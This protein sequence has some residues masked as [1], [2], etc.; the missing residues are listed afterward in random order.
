MAVMVDMCA[1]KRVAGLTLCAAALA[2]GPLRAADELPAGAEAQSPVQR[3]V[4]GSGRVSA[5]NVPTSWSEAGG[6]NLLWKAPIDL[7]AW[8]SPIVWK[9]RVIALGADAG[10]RVAVCLNAADGRRLWTT[11]IAPCEG[12]VGSYK[13]Y[14]SDPD[15]RWDRLLHAGATPATNGRQV[16]ALFSN[17][18]L[19]ALDL[20]DGKLL[21][22]VAAGSPAGNTYGQCSSLLVFRNTVIAV[23]QGA[24]SSIAAY[25]AATGKAVW[26]T[27]RKAASWASPI[28]IT[29]PAGKWQVV[30]PASPSV[31]AW[32]AETGR[33]AW[34]L[35]LLT[36]RAEYCVGPSP[37]YA[38]GLVFICAK[39]SGIFAVDP[40]KGAKVWGVETL[41]EDAPVAEFISMVSDGKH[42]FHYSDYVLTCLDAKTGKVVRQKE[43]DDLA[44]IANPVMAGGRLYLST[45]DGILAV[46]A[47]PSGAFGD[48]VG[49][50]VIKDKCDSTAAI[51]DGRVFLRTDTA[52]YAL[53]AK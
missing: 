9:D 8:A 7:P 35:D 6:T 28:L 53:G 1:V 34:S 2:A 22:S 19:A 10:K 27:P 51:V 39:G 21:W 30:L 42:V 3:G 11:E 15:L 48:V 29:T 41:P 20:A 37:V 26:K 49:K 17:G 13:I 50:G 18:Q 47:D 45:S 43:F 38:D 40:D 36:G 33:E 24:D 25:D 23:V 16:F 52:V 14:T 31:T 5:T 12:L 46:Q 4:S 32:D 44:G